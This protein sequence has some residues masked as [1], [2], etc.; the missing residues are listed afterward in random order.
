[1]NTT[2]NYS[3]CPLKKRPF[4][5]MCEDDDTSSEFVIEPVQ[6]E[7]VNL[8]VAKRPKLCESK[9]DEPLS[10]VVAQTKKQLPLRDITA[11]THQPAPIY[12]QQYKV[13]YAP[14]SNLYDMLPGYTT[15]PNHDV[16]KPTPIV[17]K[18]EVEAYSPPAYIQQRE[19]SMS[20][21]A[22]YD[23]INRPE[24]Y[25]NNTIK[26]EPRYVPYK[27]H[28]QFNEM[29]PLSPG[30]SLNSVGS[31]RSSVSP[32]STDSISEEMYQQYQALPVPYHH[33][34]QHHQQQHQQPHIVTANKQQ[35][36]CHQNPAIL[37]VTPT[38]ELH[39]PQHLHYENDDKQI[40]KTETPRFQCNECGKS[41]STYSGLTKHE[42][43][44]CRAIEGNQAQ[45]TFTCTQCGKLN[46]S[47]SA[48]KMHIRTHTLPNKCHICDKAFSRP[49][50]LQGHIRTH[51]GEKPFSCQFC[52]RAFADRSNLRAHL[53]THSDV[54]KYSCSACDK[55]FS[56]M[57]LLTKHTE[58]G[59]P[60]LMMH[61]QYGTAL[62]APIQ[63]SHHSD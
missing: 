50:L 59:C 17:I 16:S 47:L 18:R 12:E 6:E 14:A 53:Q 25:R 61:H 37:T 23:R 41:Y 31:S 3:N 48:M 54:K 35:V 63:Y 5:V 38:N 9:L 10:L 7:P 40:R 2:K 8:S 45:K 46:K 29:P 44:H 36:L 56:R 34:H 1:M 27:H 4:P 28:H 20:P 26:S 42:Q 60:G 32:A 57:S 51:T 43:F 24:Y 11:A 55:T 39:T 49:W 13:E 33:H 30:H 15:N 52:H 22:M 19:Y 58:G 21:P 62:P